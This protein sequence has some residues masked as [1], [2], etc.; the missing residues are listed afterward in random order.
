MEGTEHR[1]GPCWEKDFGAISG[2]PLFSRPLWFT[3]DCRRLMA[4]NSLLA[5]STLPKNPAIRENETCT[6]LR[7]TISRHVLPPFPGRG[8]LAIH[9]G[10]SLENLGLPRETGGFPVLEKGKF[11]FGKRGANAT[12]NGNHNSRRELEGVSQRG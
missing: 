2:G 11:H 9:A 7:A 3:A 4:V 12:Q 1:F 8:T 5:K 10:D 6:N